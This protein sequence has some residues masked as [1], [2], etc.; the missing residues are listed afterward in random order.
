MTYFLLV[1]ASRQAIS[2]NI[3]GMIDWYFD[4]QR[5]KKYNP[6][7]SDLNLPTSLHIG[8]S[9]IINRLRNWELQNT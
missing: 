3:Q 6:E 2:S 8:L 9:Y 1:Q 4:M 7:W 5:V